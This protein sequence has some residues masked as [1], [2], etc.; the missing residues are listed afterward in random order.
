MGIDP[1]LAFAVVSVVGTVLASQFDL[2]KKRI[3]FDNRL[4][5]KEQEFEAENQKRDD[6]WRDMIAKN[7]LQWQEFARR[8]LETSEK[9][10]KRLGNA[11]EATVS[12][13][14]ALREVNAELDTRSRDRGERIEQLLIKLE[15][16]R[17]DLLKTTEATARREGQLST[18][19]TQLKRKVDDQELTINR[20]NREV[21]QLA[22]Q[23]RVLR[24][25]N[26]QLEADNKL[27]LIEKGESV[28]RE[29]ELLKRI[30]ELEARVAV[31]QQENA[32]LRNEINQLKKWKEEGHE[33]QQNGIHHLYDRPALP[34][35]AV[36]SGGAGAGDADDPAAG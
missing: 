10:I 6:L 13:I 18:E 33:T 25:Q 4:K 12:Q 29:Q 17:Q 11:Y 30:E 34:G 14:S 24:E 31:L 27:L 7:D 5:E 3:E 15:A 22:E 36:A 23:N 9:E 26:T 1:Q 20:L 19:L 28:D 35:G 21:M 8:Q 16:A 2:R 32:T